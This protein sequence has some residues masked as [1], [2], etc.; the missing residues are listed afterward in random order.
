M[1]KLGYI[2]D[3]YGKQFNISIAN[4][5]S[6]NI[7]S[8]SN[9]PINSFIICSNIDD[10]G[11][12]TGTYSLIATDN[13]GNPVRLTYTIKEGNGLYYN[14]K[15]DY[16]ELN[17]DNDTII[18]TNNGLSFDIKN[19][20]NKDFIY[21]NSKNITINKDNIPNSSVNTLGISAV[22]GKTIIADNGILLVD[23]SKL[24]YSNNATN[25]YGTVIG[26]NNTI[27]IDNGTIKLNL[28]NLNK[29]D[30]EQYGI[31]T[32]DNY[33]V[34]VKNGIMSVVTENLNIA[35]ENSLGISKPDFNTI[36]LNED[37]QITV[38]ENNLQIA[39]PTNYGLSKIDT[40][41]LDIDSA[42]R[43]SMKN[44]SLIKESIEKYKDIALNY[45][46]KV[47][48]YIDYLSLGTILLRQN[49]IVLFAIT[50]TSVTELEKPKK[51]EEV[52]NMP[53]QFTSATFDII[54]TC[55]FILSIIFDEGTNE[56]PN[57]DVVE[58]NY[59]DER[60]YTKEEALD[61]LTVYPSTN[62]ELK[63]LIVKFSGKNFRNTTKG[64]S[65]VTSVNILASDSVDHIRIKH[66]KYSIVRYNSIY[67]ESYR[68][69]EESKE[70]H[71]IL[72]ENSVK[73]C[74]AD[75]KNK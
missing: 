36:V 68:D 15:N 46:N 72:V 18:E 40:N 22:D 45:K 41:T 42:N 1:S 19:H 25:Q 10:N 54:T 66:E 64:Y 52:I 30:G 73:W 71:Y 49:D 17:I 23:T 31:A 20:L 24:T 28:N 58:V 33:T 44:Y 38:N 32:V 21:V 61:P 51:D 75:R 8:G 27:F 63:R 69:R 35:T 4:T 62:G 43:I 59:N 74:P 13:Y 34:N 16:I 6:Y 5:Y 37:E 60:I 29:A 70:A 9:L 14:E 53:L 67:D 3:S 11:K 65:L 50:E 39:S 47:N 57:V 56:F 2:Y 7:L 26:D 55:D 12:D 48:D